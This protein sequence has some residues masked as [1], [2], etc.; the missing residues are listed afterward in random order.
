MN[1]NLVL[2]NPTRKFSDEDESSEGL[3]FEVTNLLVPVEGKVL[4]NHTIIFTQ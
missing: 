1:L 4:G 3:D 2:G